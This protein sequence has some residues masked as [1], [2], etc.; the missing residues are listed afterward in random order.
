MEFIQNSIKMAKKFIYIEDQYFVSR[1]IKA[2]LLKKLID[3]D[4]A[5][6][7]ILMQ[8]SALFESGPDLLDNEF[9]YLI[10]A[11]NEIR[12]DFLKVDPKQN[13][14]R[15]FTL[16]ASQNEG[17]QKFCGS[18]VHSKTM[19]FDDDFAVIGSA[20][21]DNRGYTYDTEIAVGVTDDPFGRVSAQR[22]SRNLRI[23]LW[24]KHLGL[25]QTLLTDW[26][27]SLRFWISPP[28]Q[29]M[30]V[31]SSALEDSPMLG[32]KAILRDFPQ[33]DRLWREDIDPDADLLPLAASS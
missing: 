4:F 22:F 9:P 11:R 30:I 27:G 6:L 2:E 7:L 25:S 12:T 18:Y 17:R 29:A 26:H 33:A 10:A 20:N 8:D 23:N 13:K 3:Q 19:I 31:D 15:M 14:W 16:R 24:H 28:Q 32:P 21:A 5:F 1:R